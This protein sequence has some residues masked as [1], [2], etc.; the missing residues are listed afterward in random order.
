MISSQAVSFHCPVDLLGDDPVA[1]FASE[2]TLRASDRHH[3]LPFPADDCETRRG[4]SSIASP[5]SSCARPGSGFLET[6]FGKT[7]QD[8]AVELSD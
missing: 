5:M 1:P 6:C 8:A 3:L 2:I 4:E 7:F